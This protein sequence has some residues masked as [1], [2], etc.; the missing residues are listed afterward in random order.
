MERLRLA[1]GLSCRPMVNPAPSPRA[2]PMRKAKRSRTRRSTTSSNRIFP[3]AHINICSVLPP[4]FGCDQTSCGKL[5]K[6]TGPGRRGDRFPIVDLVRKSG[7]TKVIGA[8]PMDYCAARGAEW[9]TDF[10]E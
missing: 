8:K 4:P 7:A 6:Q 1:V 3:E 2:E 5:P 9:R 10:V